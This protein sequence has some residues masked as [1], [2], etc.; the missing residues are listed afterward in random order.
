LKNKKK[1]CYVHVTPNSV[2]PNEHDVSAQ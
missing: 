1:H 2:Q